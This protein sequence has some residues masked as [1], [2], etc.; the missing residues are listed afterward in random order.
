MCS[1]LH[2]QCLVKDGCPWNAFCL[3]FL[4]VQVT[5]LQGVETSNI[6]VLQAILNYLPNI[7]ILGRFRNRD[8]RFPVPE[9]N[10]ISLTTNPLVSGLR[11]SAIFQK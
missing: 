4:N 6:F 8:G 1:H 9:E 7:K 5:R 11:V 10:R 2:L 3:I